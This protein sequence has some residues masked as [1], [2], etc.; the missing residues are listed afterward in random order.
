MQKFRIRPQGFTVFELFI[1][2][3][4]LVSVFTAFVT[5]FYALSSYSKRSYHLLAASDLAYAKLTSYTQRSFLQVTEGKS[6]SGFVVENFSSELPETIGNTRSG[7]V[8][9]SP[10][11]GSTALR[12]IDVVVDFGDHSDMRTVHYAALVHAQGVN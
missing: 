5:L 2:C 9:V 6:E 3:V 10:I 8:Y 11:N 1:T 4:V 7:T 12:K